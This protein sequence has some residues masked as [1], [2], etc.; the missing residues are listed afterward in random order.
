[1][2]GESVEDDL[3]VPKAAA[4]MASDGGRLCP[5][6]GCWVEAS[7]KQAQREPAG[8]ELDVGTWR[9]LVT[10][11]ERHRTALGRQSRGASEGG[12]PRF[13]ERHAGTLGIG[14]RPRW[15]GLRDPAGARARPG[16]SSHTRR[17]GLSET[18]WGL[19]PAAG[20]GAGLGSVRLTRLLPRACRGDQHSLSS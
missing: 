11:A 2:K 20:R 1:M 18:P 9:P 5:R 6:W 16:G 10:L 17:R 7:I 13:L 19:E 12:W 8:K 14:G 3:A 15:E 4:A